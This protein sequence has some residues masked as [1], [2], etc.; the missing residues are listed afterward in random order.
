MAR[1]RPRFQRAHGCRANGHYAATALAALPG[2]DLVVAGHTHR[3]FPSTG[4]PGGPGIDAARGT[5]AG[6][7]A[8]MPGFW[9]THLGL[10]DLRLEHEG[11]T[12]RIAGFACRAEPVGPGSDHPAVVA[13]A[14][15]A[16]RQTLRHFRRRIGK[17][18]RPLSSYFALI[19]QDSG[20]RLVAM[21]QPAE[22]AANTSSPP[23]ITRR[24]PSASD[25]GPCTMHITA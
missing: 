3:V 15:S 7:P 9:G 21:A 23:S 5:L 18:D 2:I 25:S 10:I 13:P 16:H 14:L 8:V 24:R 1:A 20:L 12:W 17:T 19:G 22:A 11:A 6:K 4:H